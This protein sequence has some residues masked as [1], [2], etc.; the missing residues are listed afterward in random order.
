MLSLS[1]H[2]YLFFTIIKKNS[3]HKGTIY[4]CCLGILDNLT[5]YWGWRLLSWFWD[6][7][8]LDSPILNS[9]VCVYKIKYKYY[10][11]IVR[12]LINLFCQ[13]TNPINLFDRVCHVAR[14]DWTFAEHIFFDYMQKNTFLLEKSSRN[15]IYA[16]TFI[17]FCLNINIPWTLMILMS[18]N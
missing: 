17:Y 5:K 15:N 13:L 12:N 16:G 11:R 18:T 14:D 8:Y 10:I 2:L 9:I 4:Y 7:C 1:L 6:F 3:V